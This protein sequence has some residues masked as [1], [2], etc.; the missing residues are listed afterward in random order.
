MMEVKE[1]YKIV[2]FMGLVRQ[3]RKPIVLLYI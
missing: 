2:R 3:A 1:R